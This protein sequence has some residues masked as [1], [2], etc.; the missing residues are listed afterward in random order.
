MNCLNCAICLAVLLLSATPVLPQDD[1]RLARV[2]SEFQK[3]TEPP[4]LDDLRFTGLRRIA[5]AAVATQIASHP[6]DRFDSVTIDKDVRAL[7]RLGWFESIQVEAISATA[8]FLLTPGDSKRVALIFHLREFPVLFKVE[9]A[10]SRLLSPKQI[11]KMLEEKKLTPQL[12]KPADPAA[13]QRIALL[14]RTGLI[15]LGHPDASVRITRQEA[16]NA[17]VR[18]RFEISDGPLL[19][20]RRVIFDGHPQLSTKLLHAQ[21]RSIAPWKPL[22]SWRGKNAYTRD[23]FEEDRQRILTYY[24][25]HG[26]PEA[27]VGSPLVVHSAET[28]RRRFPWPHE[29]AAAGLTV[30]IPVEAGPL[31]K[32]KSLAATDALQQAARGSGRSPVNLP[33]LGASRA[34]SQQEIEGL[35]RLW[36]A[37]IQS[38]RTA[39][40]SLPAPSVNVICSFNPEDHTTSVTFD[41]SDSPPYLVQRIEFL[42]LHKFSDRYVRRRILLREGQPVDER[43]LEAGL[44]R[45]ARTGYF[46]PI[47]KEDIH[48]QLDEAAHTANVTIRLQEIGQQRATLAGGTGQFGSTLGIVYTVFDLLNR[49]ELLSV[50]LDGGPESLQIVLG[51]AKEGIFGTRAS[52][53][54]SVFNSVIRPRFATSAKGPFFTSRTEGISIP[55]TYPLTDLDLLGVNFILSRATSEYPLG[56]P[57]GLTGLPPLDVRSQVSSHS[58]GIGWAHDKGSERV[59]FSNSASGGWLGGGENMVRSSAEYAR[60]FRDP[61]FAPTNAWAFRTTISGAGSYRGEMPFYSRFFSGN[62]LVRGLRPGELGPFS[63]TITTAASGATIPSASPAGANLVGAANAEYRISLGGGTQAAGFFDLGSGV[64]LP[65][66]LGPTK[67]LLLGATNGILHG[68]AGI[69]LRWTVPGVQVPVRAYYAVNILRL[70]RFI[71]LSDKSRFLA[72]DRFCA[73]GWGLG[74]LF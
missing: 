24:Q 53:A 74:S 21:M 20:V 30:S 29:S 38:P 70:D 58:L 41:L 14:I 52:L 69:E 35:R 43:A 23:A 64:L 32:F 51:L 45:L 22:A 31:Y 33:E 65:N 8:P 15:E 46:K 55:W 63:R 16:G 28:S 54:F 44:L 39:L 6:G 40:E 62:E 67:P 59:S 60:L 37:R 18:V 4:V 47:H 26:F 27:R 56:A 68:S 2:P 50:Q 36:M 12:G 72:H 25:D 49:E 5:P 3:A 7:A 13:L 73:F 48:V 9:F 10:G 71:S 34:F 19:R 57:P 11:E 61:F 66:W 42:G 17:T 1:V